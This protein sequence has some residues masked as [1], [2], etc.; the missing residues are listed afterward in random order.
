MLEH[1]AGSIRQNSLQFRLMK[2]LIFHSDIPSQ[3]AAIVAACG[4]GATAG[5]RS[6][7]IS[8]TQQEA[9]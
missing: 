1:G 4:S 6:D 9:S 8:L 7:R 5:A 3:A 2:D